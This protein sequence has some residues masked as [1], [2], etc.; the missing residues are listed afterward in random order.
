VT[1][2]YG[3]DTILKR[4]ELAVQIGNVI[5][6]WS[7]VEGTLMHFYALLL[8]DYLDSSPNMPGFVA[9][10][11]HPVAFQIFDEVNTLQTRLNLLT[12][13][14]S[15]RLLEHEFKLFRDELAPEIR[16]RAQERNAIVHGEW[17]VS[18]DYPD[19]L[20]LSQIYGHSQLW[21]KADFEEVS[22]RIIELK[23]KLDAFHHEAYRRRYLQINPHAEP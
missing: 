6:N 9:P 17:S 21:K 16:R 7:Y 20:I 4:P 18:G 14:C 1:A 19:G 22:K 13:I 5:A 3:P 2:N 11:S 10:P 15:W 23:A 12:A 8:G